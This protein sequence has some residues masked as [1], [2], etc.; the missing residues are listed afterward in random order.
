MNADHKR[1]MLPK[2]SS[3]VCIRNKKVKSKSANFFNKIKPNVGK[4]ALQRLTLNGW[5]EN[6]K[7]KYIVK[8]REDDEFLRRFCSSLS[9]SLQVNN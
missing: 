6:L 2:E 9:S 4:A 5:R 3:S 8:A 7:K 1:K